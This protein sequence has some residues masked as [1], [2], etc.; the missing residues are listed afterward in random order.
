MFCCFCC[1]FSVLHH[2]LE[3][4]GSIGN[5]QNHRLR[6]NV[7]CQIFLKMSLRSNKNSLFTVHGTCPHATGCHLPGAS[8]N[9]TDQNNKIQRG[10]PKHSSKLNASL[11]LWDSLLMLG[12][13]W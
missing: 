2:D 9:V 8:G 11:V 13:K 7:L 10:K 4:V 1:A 3:S 12:Q 6:C 5:A